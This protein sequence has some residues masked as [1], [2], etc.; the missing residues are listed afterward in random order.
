MLQPS[1][2]TALKGVITVKDNRLAFK[3]LQISEYEDQHLV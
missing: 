2:I 1:I 3:Y